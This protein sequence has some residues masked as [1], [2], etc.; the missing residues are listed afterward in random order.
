MKSKALYV[1]ILVSVVC[2][3]ATNRSTLES[4]PDGRHKILASSLLQRH[5]SEDAEVF[6]RAGGEGYIMSSGGG[7]LIFP[8][9]LQDQD[10]DYS[11]RFEALQQFEPRLYSELSP[12]LIDPEGGLTIPEIFADNISR[13]RAF[14][15]STRSAYATK[16]NRRMAHLRSNKAN[17]PRHATTTSRPVSMISPDYKPNTVID[18]RRRW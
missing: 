15:L 14:Y 18:V 16:F 6:R 10:E 8:I 11:A 12:L 17:K 9:G 5:P 7:G 4:L 2:G 13:E 3:C 1:I